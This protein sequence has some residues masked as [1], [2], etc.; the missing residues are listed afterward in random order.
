[1]SRGGTGGRG[2]GTREQQ[3]PERVP[4]LDFRFSG[5]PVPGPRSRTLHLI[6][7]GTFDPIHNGHLAIARAARDAFAVPVRL[8][9][10]ADPPHRQ[11]PGADARQRCEMLALAIAGEAGLLLDRHELQRAL[12]QPGVASYSIDTVRE[13]RAEL[14]PATSLALLIGAD[15]L[16]GFNTWRD[17]RGLL[18]AVHLVV[19]DRADSGWERAL[20]AELAQALAGRW[21]ASPQA[22][23]GA[24]GGLLWCLRQPLRSESASQVRARIAAGGDWAGLV[25]A[26]VA[27]YIRAAGLYAAAPAASAPAS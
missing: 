25:P 24:P 20:P 9:P 23:A 15:S 18:D 17:W 13:L 10:A 26:A 14:G 2:P 6:Y 5:S 12:A 7:G 21:A 1:M 27:D 11:A 16:V 3:N 4:S 19:A 22:L 8:M